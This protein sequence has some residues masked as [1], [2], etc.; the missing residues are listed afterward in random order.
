LRNPAF[1][2]G[3]MDFRNC[4]WCSPDKARAVFNSS[5]PALAGTRGH[6]SSQKNGGRKMKRKLFSLS[7]RQVY[8]VD[9]SGRVARDSRAAKAESAEQETHCSTENVGEPKIE[10]RLLRGPEQLLF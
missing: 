6:N 10:M 2:T 5:R 7:D 8:R 3:K 9:A 1:A 4:A